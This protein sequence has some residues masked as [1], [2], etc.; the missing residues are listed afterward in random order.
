MKFQLTHVL[1]VSPATFWGR[2]FF[3]RTYNEHLYQALGFANM[4]V[5]E[6]EERADGCVRRLLRAEPPL[7]VPAILKSKLQGKIFYTEDGIYDP[8]AQTWVFRSI[9]S[10]VPDQ[11]SITG[12]IQLSPH[13]KGALHAVEVEARVTAW[14]VGALIERVIER[15][16]R[17]SFAITTQFIDRWAAEKGLS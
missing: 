5:L 16:T 10:V 2:L 17:D 15:N 14:G 12:R 11:V 7:H 4:Q 6:L 3:D 13:A 9:P 8:A 1:S